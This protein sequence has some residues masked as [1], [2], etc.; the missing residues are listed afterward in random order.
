V[1]SVVILGAGEL[2][3]AVAQAVVAATV[4]GRVVL[5][6]D[7]RE[8][9]AGKAL[10]IRQAAPVA[11]H[12]GEISGTADLAA[13]VGAAAVVIADRH[14]APPRDWQGDEALQLLARV[15][16]LNARALVVGAGPGHLA[17]VERAV[18]EQGADRGRLI[19]SAPEALRGAVTAL[20]SLEAGCGPGDVSLALLGRPPS[21]A[22]VPWDQ[23]AIAGRGATTVLEPT[24][25][26]RLDQRLI[27]LWPPGPVA[28][29]AAA[30][31]VLRL[32]LARTPGT[33][34]VFGV[35]PGTAGPAPRGAVLPATFADGGATLV[36]PAL[37]ARDRVRLD[38]TLAAG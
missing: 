10:D 35:P 36:V 21:G 8:V 30:A 7:A 16:A 1:S 17:L 9:A 31:R 6:D 20:A 2:G 15:R 5:V 3:G 12:D 24:A 19:A 13:V 34:Y 18:A 11:G 25:L 22:F 32:A 28:C 37:S 14:G 4:V 23:A 27:R 33:A 29:A 38:G 26:R